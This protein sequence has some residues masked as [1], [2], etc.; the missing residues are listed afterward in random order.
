MLIFSRLY[1][2]YHN[3]TQV[4]RSALQH[5]PYSVRLHAAAISMWIT[6]GELVRAL[7]YAEQ[8]PFSLL[9]GDVSTVDPNLLYWSVQTSRQSRKLYLGNL[10]ITCC[11][12][13]P[14]KYAPWYCNQC[15]NHHL[16]L[17]CCLLHAFNMLYYIVSYAVTLIVYSLRTSS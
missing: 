15:R 4:L 5:V 6:R 9:D 13:A 12:M 1:L 8:C 14:I 16:F 10:C 17:A 11:V 2:W 3:V 7:Q